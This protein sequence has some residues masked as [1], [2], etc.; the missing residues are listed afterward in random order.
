MACICLNKVL[1]TQIEMKPRHVT[2]LR[3]FLGMYLVH[4]S[5]SL[6]MALCKHWGKGRRTG[7]GVLIA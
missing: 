5:H 4:H 2:C 3:R 6:A 1:F 7:R